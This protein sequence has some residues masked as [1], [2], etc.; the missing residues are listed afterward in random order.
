M[1]G[2]REVLEGEDLTMDLGE[3]GTIVLIEGVEI[4]V[5]IEEGV[6]AI[7]TT[8]EVEDSAEVAEGLQ[9]KEEDVEMEENRSQEEEDEYRL[10]IKKLIFWLYFRASPQQLGTIG[11][12]SRSGPER[13]NDI[14]L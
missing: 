1:K 6:E 9:W 7:E 4:I 14:L 5:L 12:I 13:I 3:E 8:E 11:S 10:K 2:A